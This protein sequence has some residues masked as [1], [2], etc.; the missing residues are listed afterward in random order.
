MSQ[1]LL[2]LSL[3]VYAL[4]SWLILLVVAG[5]FNAL[6]QALVDSALLAAMTYGVLISARYGARF[7]QTLS[8]LAGAGALLGLVAL[9]IFVWIDQEIAR[10]GNPGLPRLLFLGLVVWNVAVIAHVLHHA[11]SVN[12]W[13]GLLYALGFFIVSMLIMQMLFPADA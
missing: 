4:S 6:L 11:L 2:K 8:A 3:T 1:A 9:P 7:V 12:R 5:P 10:S 13:A